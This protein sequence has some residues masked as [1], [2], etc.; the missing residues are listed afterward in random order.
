MNETQQLAQF[1][2]ELK[3]EDLS[4]EIITKAKGLVLD[5]LGC[6]L[7]FATLPWSRIIYQHVRD[8]TG[9]GESTI[10]YY[11]LRTTMEDTAFVNAAFG[12]GFEMDDTEM[13]TISHPGSVVIP[14]ALATG[15]VKHASGREFLTAVV[16]G[17]DVMLRVGQAARSMVER[18][19]HTTSVSGPFG[20]AATTNKILQ[21][22]ADTIVNTLGIAASEAGGIS[23]Y[24]I[25]GGSVKR[26]HSGFPAYA[27]V[28]AA[29]LAQG[30]ITGPVNA[31]EGKKGFCQA[32]ANETY[33]ENIT[34]GLGREFRIMWTGNKTYCCCAAQHTAIDAT[35]AIMDAHVFQVG[36]I[37]EIIIEQMPREVKSVGNI[38]EPGDITAAQFSG[39]FGVA[40]RLIKGGNGFNDYTLDNIKNPEIL[41][42]ARKTRYETNEKL[43]E[44]A[45]EAAPAVVT[46]R[47]KNGDV[48]KKRVDYARGTIQNPLT[49]QELEDKF[50]G[51]ASLSVPGQQVE[52]IVETIDKLEDVADIRKLVSLLIIPD[53][54]K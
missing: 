42:L 28:K 12:H 19:F 40:M 29:L 51:L 27:G 16:A 6:Q 48:L 46:I 9:T 30:G 33:L 4:P 18:S 23:E 53:G 52:D 49:A 44:K 25:S 3:Y 11:G 31:I 1:V 36:D 45:S 26:L 37:D 38:I 47:L 34:A 2:A 15:E 10:I 5:Q 41:E 20:A 17:Y 14:A 22:D 8:K 13:H 32:F 39:R 35:R 24:T 43:K 21:H 54:D 50:R 7:A